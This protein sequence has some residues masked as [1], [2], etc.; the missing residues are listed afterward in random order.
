MNQEQVSAVVRWVIAVLPG[1][2]LGVYAISKG[3]ISAS[4]IELIGG[5]LT[6]VVPLVWSLFVHTKSNTVAV[7]AAMPEVAK[8]EATNTPEGRALAADAGSAPDAIVT[9]AP[10]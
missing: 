3:W 6:A 2:A 5:A 10:R 8:V 1:S 9:V 4:Q 7:V